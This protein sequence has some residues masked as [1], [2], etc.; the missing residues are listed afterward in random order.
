MKKIMILAA[1]LSSSVSFAMPNCSEKLTKITNELDRAYVHIVG[2]AQGDYEETPLT[3]S[4]KSSK[5]T[6]KGT[7]DTYRVVGA[8][9]N[10]EGG[11]WDDTYEITLAN[12]G[13]YLETYQFLG[14]K[15]TK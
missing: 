5:K 12:P 1:I 6:L 11:A 9:I 7:L 8:H 3:I 14:S 4:D 2:V 13:C 10:D 15:I